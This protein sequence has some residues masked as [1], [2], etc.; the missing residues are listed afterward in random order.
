MLDLHT[1]E[2]G[3]TEIEPPVLVRDEAMFGTAQLPKFLDDQFMRQGT[4]IGRNCFVKR[5]N[6]S[7]PKSCRD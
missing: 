1:T 5:F 7:L 2:H 3:Y 4:R 6:T